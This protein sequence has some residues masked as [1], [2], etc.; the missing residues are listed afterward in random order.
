MED[1]QSI[2]AHILDQINEVFFR[3]DKE[4][5]LVMVGGASFRVLGYDSVEDL[6]G[7]PVD[8]FWYVPEERQKFLREVD[9]RGIVTNHEM[10]LRKK[11]G[12]PL[13]VEVSS[14]FYRDE[15]GDVLGTEG[16]VHDI[17]DRNAGEVARKES[18]SKYRLIFE[19]PG[20]PYALIDE[21]TGLMI[22]ANQA[23]LD[24]YGYS[25]E[26]LVGMHHSSFS[27]E[28]DVSRAA[29]KAGFTHVP[30]VHHIRKDGSVFPVEIYAS[31]CR[32]Q[33]KDVRISSVREISL[34]VNALKA[35]AESEARYRGIVDSQRDIVVRS[36]L[37]FHATYANDA[38]RRMTGVDIGKPGIDIRHAVF[39]PDEYAAMD[40]HN[41]NLLE[42]PHR[43]YSELRLK[44]LE[45]WRW[46]SF[47][48][49]L[50]HDTDGNVAEIQTVAHDIHEQKTAEQELAAHA[51]RLSLATEA[52]SEGVWEYDIGSGEVY[53]SPQMFALIGYTPEEHAG[54]K[55]MQSLHPDDYAD[56]RKHVE[57]HI[58]G[59]ND[60]VDMEYRIF[61]KS[62]ELR[63]VH[64]R[65]RVTQ[66]DSEGLPLAVGGTM[67][68]IT[69]A[70]MAFEA[71]EK[72]LAYVKEAYSAQKEFLN[73]VRHEIRT[74]LISVKGYADMLLEGLGGPVTE[75]QKQYLE[76]V[77][78]SSDALLAGVSA[79]LEMSRLRSGKVDVAYEIFSP[80][81]LVSKLVT[82]LAP[83]AHQKGLKLEVH[84]CGCRSSG[85]TDSTK[86]SVIF[87][88]LLSNAIKF[89]DKGGVDVYVDSDESG[90]SVGVVDTGKGMLE[91]EVADIFEEFMQLQSSSKYKE[92]GFGIGLS[93]SAALVEALGASL[94][95]STKHGVGSAFTLRV[96]KLDPD[97][98]Q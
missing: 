28:P 14:Q 42:P 75:E 54:R 96:P 88:N 52:A 11:D 85:V 60:R 86:F 49:Y 97:A 50:I 2:Y 73:C 18:D 29:I 38:W 58:A 89:T 4:G 48:S 83:L 6:I 53:L 98:A 40:Q 10:A 25:R 24:Q 81:R 80:G 79:M 94:V 17:S 39:H 31:V 23:F 92:G 16:V 36:D 34:R 93:L 21:A 67:T 57:D 9:A 76:K 82:G 72:A 13:Q 61:K 68:D 62:G 33:D 74:P 15:Q 26:E 32:L 47:E 46:Y 78:D 59:L 55:Y 63:W 69:E 8:S 43:V 41:A 70:H 45:G 1:S 20:V 65:G 71:L 22:D 27:A 12:T 7:K 91:S 84:D 77:R 51:R 3:T 35:L 5:R 56:F 30:I 44:T 37:G 64:S 66:R 90:F 95:V 87:S 19:A